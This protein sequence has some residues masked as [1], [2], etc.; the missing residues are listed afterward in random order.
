MSRIARS[1]EPFASAD[2]PAA[3]PL[4]QGEDVERLRAF[5][6]LAPGQPIRDGLLKLQA[7]KSPAALGVTTWEIRDDQLLIDG[8]TLEEVEHE[9]AELD[10]LYAV[11][12]AQFEPKRRAFDDWLGT[13]KRK[14]HLGEALDADPEFRAAHARLKRA[15]AEHD[16]TWEAIKALSDRDDVRRDLALGLA[17]RRQLLLVRLFG[18]LMRQRDVTAGASRGA[19]PPAPPLIVEGYRAEVRR[20]PS[21]APAARFTA[22]I[23]ALRG[24]VFEARTEAQAVRRLRAAVPGYLAALRA[25]GQP[26]PAPDA[27]Q[28]VTDGR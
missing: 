8:E 15:D 12:D 21:A 27:R 22:Q 10:R 5:L 18:E 11:L 6:R 28:E 23:G 14:G 26:V 3:G 7:P 2:L 13:V 24:C 17:L 25:T 9:R 20:D 1:H 16:S 19:A 4:F